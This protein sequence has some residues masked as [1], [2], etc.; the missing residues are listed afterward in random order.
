MEYFQHPHLPGV[1]GNNI[2]QTEVKEGIFHDRTS[3]SEHESK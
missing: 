1:N 3:P 2:P